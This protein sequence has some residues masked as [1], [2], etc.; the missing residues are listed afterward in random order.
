MKWL[1]ELLEEE[2]IPHKEELKE[3]WEGT[4]YAKYEPK[5][6]VYVPKECKEK[7]ELYLKEYSNPDNISCENA[8]ELKN[9]SNDEEEQKIQTKKRNNS[10]KILAL[11]PIVMILVAILCAI[12]MG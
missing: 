4:K 7:V 8:D 1:F 9:I 12:I 6:N 3:H 5:V 11:I 2:K 10:K